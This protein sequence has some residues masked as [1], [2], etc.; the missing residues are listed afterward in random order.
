MD[1]LTH[2]LVGAVTSQAFFARRLGRLAPL[3]GGLAGVLPDVDRV[4]QFSNHPLTT[5]QVHQQFTHALW[6]IPIG[7]L[8]AMLP[9]FWLKQLRYRRRALMAAA[10][11]AYASH[12]IV[13]VLSTQGTAIFWPLSDWR[14]ALDW[15]P[16]F[17]PLLLVVL[18]AGVT[19]ALVKV[20]PRAGKVAL[21]AAAL[22]AGVGAA[23]HERAISVQ[24]QLVDARMHTQTSRRVLP[25][26]NNLVVWRSMYR[27][28]NQIFIDAIRV[29]LG[30][31][32]PSYRAGGWSR[33]FS[34]DQLPKALRQ[35]VQVEQAQ[36]LVQLTDHWVAFVPRT[37]GIA[38]P[39]MDIRF[40]P[41]PEGW[42]S[43]LGIQLDSKTPDAPAAYVKHD[44]TDPAPWSDRWRDLTSETGPAPVKPKQVSS[45][46]RNQPANAKNIVTQPLAEP[47][48]SNTF[49]PLP[50][51]ENAFD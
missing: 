25:T 51:I 17:D 27:V 5:M 34:V 40:S 32:E 47:E 10:M 18:L 36:Q 41:R 50:T 28:S 15:L 1:P 48:V 45:T 14:V 11:I 31:S 39:L 44:M 16:Y 8:L 20:E 7:G 21:I 12:A 29:P 49:I 35:S 37:Q 43:R 9:F 13:D 30:G 23:Q 33:T 46:R 4:L 22:Y 3:V 26:Q 38:S 24:E 42:V 6:F 19:A 2:F